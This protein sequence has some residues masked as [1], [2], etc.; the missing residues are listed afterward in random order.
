MDVLFELLFG[1]F[2]EMPLEMAMESRR[3]K[4]WVKTVL[5]F[6]VFNLITILMI[7]IALD[8]YHD[9]EAVGGWQSAV[10]FAVLFFAASL[11]ICVTGHRRGW[12]KER[13]CPLPKPNA[14][15]QRNVP[16]P[17][18][19]IRTAHLTDLDAIAAVEAACFPAAEAATRDEFADRLRYYA[20]HFWLMFDGDKLVSFVDG[21]VTNEPD[22]TDEMYANASMHNAAGEWQMIFGVNTIPAYRDHGYAAQLIGR[23]IQ[24]A[25]DQGRKG[26]VLT[27]KPEKVPYYI[28]FGFVNEGISKNSTH[29]GAVWHQMRL[30]F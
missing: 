5:L 27:C 3:L 22:L 8:L 24:D 15:P 28:K 20:N 2:F 1:I 30:T 16:N 23:A 12:Q 13:T 21:F 26:V 11:F 19:T 18:M 9:P 7:F 29:G 17:G 6:V 14:V 25:R 4:P 10:G